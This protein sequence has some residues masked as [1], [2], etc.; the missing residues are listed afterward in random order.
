MSV[1]LTIVLPGDEIPSSALPK[2]QNQKKALTLGPGLRHIPPGTITTTIAG[3][4]VTDNK[5]N[6]AW[7]EYNSGR[8]L[9]STND[10]IIATVNT[11][12]GEAFNCFI[13]PNTPLATL[14]HLAFEGATKKTRP[15]L[16]PNALVYA[17][18]ANPGRDSIP[19]LTCVDASGKGDGLGPLKGGM[20]FKI[21]LGMARR[22]LAGRKKGE[23]VVLEGL[24]EKVGF[25]VAIGRNGYLWVDGGNVKTTLA[26]GRAVQEVDEQ[27]LG[28][29]GQR[30][31]V[32]RVLKSL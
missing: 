5:K 1:S 14:P 31:V 24:S 27:A 7:I 30:K 3:A 15:Q 25:E 18:V 6:A 32:E 10:L 2:P 28:E 4:L 17:R 26:V 16:P 8:Y 20:V 23:V 21:S 13:T 22:L 11:S 12:S 9:P 19:E 29:K